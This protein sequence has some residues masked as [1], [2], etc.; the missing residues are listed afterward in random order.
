MTRH[1]TI[2]PQ[3][4]GDKFIFT[5]ELDAVGKKTI[6]IYFV[7]EKTAL[8]VYPDNITE[9]DIELVKH[10]IDG[11]LLRIKLENKKKTSEN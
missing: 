10:Q 3:R 6:P 11:I 2:I 4:I 8:F 9:D 5:S 1:V 7:G